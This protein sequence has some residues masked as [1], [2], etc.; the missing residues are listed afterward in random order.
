MY[1]I[2]VSNT[3]VL[4]QADDPETAIQL[5]LDNY[6]IAHY[7]QETGR[8]TYREAKE[9]DFKYHDNHRCPMLT[10]AGWLT[11]E[12]NRVFDSLDDDDLGYGE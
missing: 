8:V 7:G 3:E 9:I 6:R 11:E 2:T 10:P 5:A 4:V 1:L 12:D